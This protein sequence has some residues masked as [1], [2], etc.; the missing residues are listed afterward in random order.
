MRVPLVRA[1]FL[2]GALSASP[3]VRSRVR[4]ATADAIARARKRGWLPIELDVEVAEAAAQAFPDDHARRAFWR[5][6]RSTA[7][8]D[9]LFG[10]LAG[11]AFRALVRPPTLV[12]FAPRIWARV[13]KNAGELRV[14]QQGRA[15]SILALVGAAPQMTASPVYMAAIAASIEGGL[16]ATG[17]QGS[18]LCTDVD[19]QQRS[20]RFR[21]TWKPDRRSA[22][23][24]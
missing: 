5:T 8:R 10:P 22:Q 3:D 17:A 4:P 6:T 13:F 18:C 7:Y 20:A 2:Q 24:T 16:E 1:G 11:A 19:A 23:A 12:R 9:W 14:E 21:V 15:G